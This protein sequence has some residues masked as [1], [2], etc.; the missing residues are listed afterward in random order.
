M[1]VA[2]TPGV[3]TLAALAGP[4]AVSAIVPTTAHATTPVA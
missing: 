4:D 3:E 1:D 2:V